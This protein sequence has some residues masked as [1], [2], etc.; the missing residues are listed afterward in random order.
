MI[1][2][3]TSG[4]SHG[5]S[6]HAILEGIP[7]GLRLSE[8]DINRELARRQRG[9]G[10][11]ERMQK[12]EK[13][14]V[15][16]TSGL[17]WGETIGSPI[18]LVITNRD[19]ENWKKLMS[20]YASDKEMK[21]RMVRPRPGHADL[22]GALKYGRE[23]LRDIL[24]RA[25]ARETAARVAVGSVCKRLLA[26]FAIKVV[27]MTEEI[28]GIQAIISKL[29]VEEIEKVSESS[30]VRCPDKSAEKKMVEAIKKAEKSGDTLGGVFS[31]LVINPPPGLGSH[32]QWD[33]R[34]D[35]RLAQA[36]MSIPAVKGVEIGEGF[37]T[38]RKPGSE[39]HDEIFYEA[40]RGYYRKTNN[41][42]GIEGGISNGENI[43]ARA[44][45]KPLSSLKKPLKSIDMITKKSVPAE[46]V[47]ADICAV[48]AAG[49]IGE[50][51]VALEITRA[52]R[53]KFGGDSL[54]EMKANF[55][56]YME[57]LKKR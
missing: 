31:V 1:R 22:V 9:F 49:V 19:W 40:G 24:E 4:E 23:D 11:G 52:M 51:V 30:P 16:I 43:I 57:E 26:E 28:G 25:S 2:Y 48:P 13:D 8:E 10:R 17:R 56:H 29:N 34:L 20:I 21:E 18:T 7:A 15:E 53:E 54:A 32:A 36:L 47:R 38:A 12:I 37:V 35:G 27:S 45:M 42:G 50:A 44:A 6:L 46:V 41:S 3:V 33:L 39:V 5:K 55:A 14:K